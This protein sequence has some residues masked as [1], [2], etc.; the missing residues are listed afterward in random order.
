MKNKNIAKYIAGILTVST[1]IIIPSHY[2]YAEVPYDAT[3]GFKAAI[4]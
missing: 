3:K 2:V 1:M 4:F